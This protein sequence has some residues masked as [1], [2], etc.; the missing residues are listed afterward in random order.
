[1][2]KNAILLIFLLVSSVA[3]VRLLTEP[4]LTGDWH[5]KWK[6]PRIKFR[7]STPPPQ[8]IPKQQT[9]QEQRANEAMLAQQL[10][11]VYNPQAQLQQQLQQIQEEQQQKMQI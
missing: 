2:E 5:K 1:M 8:P 10:G 9:E 3:A 6:A 11:M 4:S 7:P